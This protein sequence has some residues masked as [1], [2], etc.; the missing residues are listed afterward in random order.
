MTN[1]EH[2]DLFYN[3]VKQHE[4]F[5]Q[6]TFGEPVE[7]QQWIGVLV[8][9]FKKDDGVYIL[10]EWAQVYNDFINSSEQLT[11]TIRYISDKV[12]AANTNEKVAEFIITQ[13]LERLKAD[14][15]QSEKVYVCI[16]NNW[17]KTWFDS[18][19]EV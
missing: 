15:V 14:N 2:L 8:D 5:K 17:N 4:H 3:F 1:A 10:E 18:I 16:S 6:L 13:I 11:E 12:A 9:G 7:N 19:E